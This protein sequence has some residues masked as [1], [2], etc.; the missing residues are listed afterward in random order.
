MQTIYESDRFMA[1]DR[2]LYAVDQLTG[3]EHFQ[4]LVGLIPCFMCDVNGS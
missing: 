2:V 1:L 3:C 4:W